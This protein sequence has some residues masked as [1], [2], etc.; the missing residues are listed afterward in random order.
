[1]IKKLTSCYTESLSLDQN[2]MQAIIVPLEEFSDTD[3]N[4]MCYQR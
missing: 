2:E 4:Q 3:G 1:M